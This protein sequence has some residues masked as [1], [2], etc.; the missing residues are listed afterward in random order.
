MRNSL[1]YL[2]GVITLV[3]VLGLSHVTMAY[4]SWSPTITPNPVT[5]IV[6]DLQASYTWGTSSPIGPTS[7]S[8]L[9]VYIPGNIYLG[10]YADYVYTG[11]VNFTVT[12]YNSGPTS[13][14]ATV[15]VSCPSPLGSTSASVTVG[16]TSSASVTLTLTANINGPVTSP[17]QFLQCSVYTNL[18][19]NNVTAVSVQLPI[20][21]TNYGI[22]FYGGAY[23][24]AFTISFYAPYFVYGT[25][26]YEPSLSIVPFAGLTMGSTL[27]LVQT[28]S[29]ASDTST[30][31]LPTPSSAGQTYNLEFIFVS[32]P[33]TTPSGHYYYILEPF[34]PTQLLGGKYYPVSIGTYYSQ[35][36]IPGVVINQQSGANWV[37]LYTSPG[38]ITLEFSTY[39]T[40]PVGCS[41]CSIPFYTNASQWYFYAGDM[42]S[43]SWF[44]VPA[45]AI[46]VAPGQS[47][48]V[49][50][51]MF[52]RNESI[53]G[54]HLWAPVLL[55]FNIVGLG[56][57]ANTTLLTQVN[58][59][60]TNPL[61][62]GVS[63]PQYIINVHGNY[64]WVNVTLATPIGKII[65]KALD[66]A[67]YLYSPTSITVLTGQLFSA[68]YTTSQYWG[69]DTYAYASNYY[70][71][72][73]DILAGGS[74]TPNNNTVF[75]NT[76]VSGSSM[77]PYGLV[78]IF[79]VTS[80]GTSNAP[81][82]RF[83]ISMQYVN[84][85]VT[86]YE[87]VTVVTAM[88][89]GINLAVS[90]VSLSGY[91][92]WMFNVVP[93][94]GFRQY[95]SV[96]T[97]QY[98]INVTDYTGAGWAVVYPTSSSQVN[99]TVYELYPNGTSELLG[100]K[101]VPIWVSTRVFNFTIATYYVSSS[102]TF[103]TDLILGMNQAPQVADVWYSQFVPGATVYT[104]TYSSLMSP[105]PRVT[106]SSSGYVFMGYGVP[107]DTSYGFGSTNEV[108]TDIM[109]TRYGLGTTMYVTYPSVVGTV[110]YSFS[111]PSGASDDSV[112]LFNDPVQPLSAVNVTSVSTTPSS[113]SVQAGSAVNITVTIKLSAPVQVTQ[114]FQGTVS[115]NGT[116][117][118]TFTVTVPEGASSASAT[119]MFVAPSKP[120]TYYGVVNVNG[121][122]S[123]FTLT[124]TPSY[125]QVGTVV[126]IVLVLIIIVVAVVM[127][128][129]RGGGGTVTIRI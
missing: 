52:M 56:Y 128:R 66:T 36:G 44:N 72:A 69:F 3:V 119:V 21:I 117:V 65:G 67:G 35:P 118:A 85:P 4:T 5:S 115:L 110:S 60:S 19:T 18:S 108:Y 126:L 2:I 116:T 1:I 30:F 88:N 15:Y 57:S 124:V 24:P 39:Q 75:G 6:S 68:N 9:Y 14:S 97:I 113:Q 77:V 43:G 16:A 109:V 34:L 51:L 10:Q 64:T 122:T 103:V 63:I 38:G 7:S 46:P 104:T 59:A 86:S 83:G 100:Y 28:G 23:H 8:P 27:Y 32:L 20:E 81:L 25:S 49:W 12:L 74:F 120:G 80:A 62:P 26:T 17:G 76:A 22:D 95:L 79:N 123:T 61:P 98:F 121:M 99:A 92:S 73:D 58:G 102:N 106:T 11:A 93:N 55:M 33:A 129:R 91:P 71:F 70:L 54:S 78:P 31:S 84:V 107:Y 47:E 114:A 45:Y 101:L 89:Q 105:A 29:S 87:N 41:G 112:L 111:I 42:Y 96:H 127:Y 13:G 94:L 90:G 40:L 37:T 53:Y 48:N 82:W 50:V 125:A